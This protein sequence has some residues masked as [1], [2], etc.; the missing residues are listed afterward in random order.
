MLQ[1]LPSAFSLQNSDVEFDLLQYNH[2]KSVNAV[3][4]FKKE[5]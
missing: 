4:T 3:V 5:K 2:Y 1:K